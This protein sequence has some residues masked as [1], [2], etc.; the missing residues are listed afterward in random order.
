[1]GGDDGEKC[2]WTTEVG[3]TG[4]DP[5]VRRSGVTES[6]GSAGGGAG[7]LSVCLDAEGREE[8]RGVEFLSLELCEVGQRGMFICLR[9]R[10]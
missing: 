9:F 3:V 8:S 6:V 5:M 7:R 4:E 10:E 2:R 1:M